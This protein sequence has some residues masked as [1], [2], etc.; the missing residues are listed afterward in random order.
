[1]Y[2]H[3][4]AAWG[5]VDVNYHPYPKRKQTTGDQTTVLLRELGPQLLHGTH[6]YEH[7]DYTG[8]RGSSKKTPDEALMHEA[9]QFQINHDK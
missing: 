9:L 5:I 2:T 3:M 7:L 1:M 8:C 6:I 4:L